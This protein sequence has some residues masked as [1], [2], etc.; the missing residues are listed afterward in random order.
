M[1]EEINI[2]GVDSGLSHQS[3]WLARLWSQLAQND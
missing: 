3:V 1:G 2:I